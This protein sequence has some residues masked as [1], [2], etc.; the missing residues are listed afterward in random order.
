MTWVT[1]AS[2]GTPVQLGN[3]RRTTKIRILKRNLKDMA[4]P[5]DDHSPEALEYGK[6]PFDMY[7]SLP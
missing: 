5:V 3:R 7:Q 4:S 6:F 1:L 2:V